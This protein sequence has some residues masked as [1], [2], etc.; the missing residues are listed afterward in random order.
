MSLYNNIFVKY[1]NLFMDFTK[2]WYIEIDLFLT[3]ISIVNS[4]FDISLFLQE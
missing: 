3:S 2:R 4:K 1:K